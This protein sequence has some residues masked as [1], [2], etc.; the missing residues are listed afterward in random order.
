MA[1]EY[2]KGPA[3][4]LRAFCGR[5][6][7]VRITIGKSGRQ[8]DLT[9]EEEESIENGGAEIYASNAPPGPGDM[10]PRCVGDAWRFRTA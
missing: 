1:G 6:G 10:C 2:L 3:G 9:P 4:G 8:P 7:F 5:C